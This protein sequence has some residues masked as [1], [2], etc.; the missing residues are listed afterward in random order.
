MAVKIPSPHDPHAAALAQYEVGVLRFLDMQTQGECFKFIPSTVGI[1]DMA[2]ESLTPDIRSALRGTGVFA[3][4]MMDTDLRHHVRGQG[5]SLTWQN[6]ARVCACIA[7]SLDCIHKAGVMH[8]DVK[9]ANVLLNVGRDGEVLNV[10][11]ADFGAAFMG[12]SLAVDHMGRMKTTCWYRAPEM[13][14]NQ[15]WYT[16]AVDIWSLGCVLYELVEGTPLFYV[17]PH[18]ILEQKDNQVLHCHFTSHMTPRAKEGLTK[19]HDDSSAFW[20]VD[21]SSKGMVPTRPRG[22]VLSEGPAALQLLVAQCIS[23]DPANR[24]TA[25]EV[26]DILA[27]LVSVKETAVEG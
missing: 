17:A 4:E 26:A 19:P 9:P 24:P 11:L 25:H 12:A 7:R 5:G 16:S 3:M 10:K 22:G 1:E 14:W 27:K 2:R 15:P 21:R 13:V 8:R 18:E 23:L 6:A 20:A